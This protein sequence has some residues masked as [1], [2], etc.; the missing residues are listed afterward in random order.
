MVTDVGVAMMSKEWHAHKEYDG[1][2]HHQRQGNTN[3]VGGVGVWL[4][5]MHL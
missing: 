1:K 2:H 4:Q 3:C 5:L